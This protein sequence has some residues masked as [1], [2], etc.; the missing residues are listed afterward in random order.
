[1]ATVL[2]VDDSELDRRLV[3][4]LLGK[5]LRLTIQYAADGAEALERVAAALPD[6]IV[7]DMIMPQVD[8]L[9]LVRAVV[10][11]FPRLPVVLMTGEG[12]EALA[13][14][15]LRAGATSFV[16]K[17][18]L[19]QLLVD[20]VDRLVE[21]STSAHS[22]ERLLARLS[23]LRCSFE[24]DNDLSLIPPLVSH[25]LNCLKNVGL[26]DEAVGMQIGVA[27]EEA[28][29]N[30]IY[31]GNLELSSELR[32]DQQLY[33][34]MIEERKVSAPYRERVVNVEA[35]FSRQRAAITIKDQ[36]P[37]FDPSSLPDPTDPANLER[38]SGRGVLLMRTFMDRVAY[39]AKGNEVTLEKQL[40]G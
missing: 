31:H 9:Q 1:M 13:A 10:E 16:P 30:A 29:N 25:L 40:S 21:L 11:R 18:A 12:N 28:L 35:D 26:T 38:A 8:G 33:R 2:V 39:S 22:Q 7:T 4:G 6:V 20:T 27:L 36:G 15:A 3:G 14:E 24:L 5:S 37:G 23:N 32:E 34:R 19:A 17:N